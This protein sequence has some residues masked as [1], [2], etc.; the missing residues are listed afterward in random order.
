MPFE[1]V[2][3]EL[4][5][6]KLLQPKAFPDDRGFF[7][8]T[9][10]RSDF[11]ALGIQEEMVQHNHSRSVRGVARGIHF[12]VGRGAGKIV[13]CARGEIWDVL[14]DLRRGS[15]TYGNW[16][17]FVLSDENLRMLYC[18]PGFGHGFCVL[19]NVADVTY[20]LDAYYDPATEREISPLDP[21]IGIDWPLPPG[22]IQVSDRDRQAPALAEI[23]GELPFVFTG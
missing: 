4:P 16:E 3:S 7:V 23:A 9:Y 13:R 22:E 10:R 14:V 21:A 2:P 18:P 8:E 6:P 15:P 11:M 1:I 17:G 12:T 20:L 19:S 5:G